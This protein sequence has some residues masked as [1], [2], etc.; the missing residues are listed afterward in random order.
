M[1][2]KPSFAQW[3]EDM[4]ASWTHA[5]A[6][7]LLGGAIASTLTACIAPPPAL[8]LADVAEP[9]SVAELT[10]RQIE[11]QQR[12]QVDLDLLGLGKLTSVAAPVPPELTEF[13]QAW[14]ETDAAIAPFLGYWAQDW[15][16]HPHDYMTVFPAVETGRVCLVRYRK[17]MTETVPFEEVTTPI[18][19]SIAQ[20]VDG[21]LLGTH[22]QSGRSLLLSTPVSAYLPYEA[23]FLG[24]VEPDG[25]LRLYA[26]Q[27][28]PTVD[29]TWDS[30]IQQQLDMQGCT[31]QLP[32][33]S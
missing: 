29:A 23:E 25:T 20:V 8:S 10:Q 4:S 30:K 19:V 11:L 31:S 18:E 6:S 2:V 9:L 22:T 1:P 27:Q 24:T 28:V 33:P 15:N 14:A 32:E 3:L 21:Q 26:A 7:F 17:E 5:T 12:V 13:R 16:M